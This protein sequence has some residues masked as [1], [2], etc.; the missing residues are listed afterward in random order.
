MLDALGVLV[1]I[2]V[3]VYVGD[4]FGEHGHRRKEA[5]KPEEGV[6]IDE[7]G[8][9]RNEEAVKELTIAASL[10]LPLLWGDYAGRFLSDIDALLDKTR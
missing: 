8:K 10:A 7:R 9:A 4:G 5:R 1:E 2:R 6:D 3:A